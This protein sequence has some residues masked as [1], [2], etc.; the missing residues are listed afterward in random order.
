M[1][2]LLPCALTVALVLG[3]AWANRATL[4]LPP[5][6]QADVDLVKEPRVLRWIRLQTAPWPKMVLFGDSLAQ[7]PGARVAADVERIVKQHGLVFPLD[8]SAQG[9]HALQFYAQL[10][11]VL[12]GHPSVVV[13][14]VNLP[15]LSGRA[16]GFRAGGYQPLAR[17]L[18]LTSIFALSA[19]MALDGIGPLDPLAYRLLDALDALHVADGVR[20][21]A[22]LRLEA[23]GAA[24]ADALRLRT[25]TLLALPAFDAA[26]ARE[27]LGADQTRSPTIAV[28]R[29]IAET[30]RAAGAHVLFYVSPVNVDV[31]DALGVR[32]ELNLPARV[33]A[34]RRAI[35]A[36]PEEWVDLH[37][38]LPK[39][40]FRDPWGHLVD[41]GCDAVA[42]QLVTPMIAATLR[43]RVV[44]AGTPGPASP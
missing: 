2:L 1:A 36:A 40:T 14:E 31:L 26:V 38:L 43:D 41:A 28:L 10:P 34:V 19:A 23:W 13:V 18:S 37:A 6:K 21:S 15:A 35:G 11:D 12:T 27:A 29:A 24:L 3:W 9:T 44:P 7:C 25:V 30:V 22:R 5:E 4:R 39:S 42:A 17:K 32:H 20:E 8:A 16:R 33:E